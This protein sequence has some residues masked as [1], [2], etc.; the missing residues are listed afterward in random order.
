MLPFRLKPNSGDKGIRLIDWGS[1]EQKETEK[2]ASLPLTRVYIDAAYDSECLSCPDSRGKP[3]TT[4]KEF[5]IFNNAS[6]LPIEVSMSVAPANE[7]KLQFSVSYDYIGDSYFAS[8]PVSFEPA[9]L[10][11]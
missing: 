5:K 2:Y 1:L 3:S 10:T 7:L 9:E 6:Y 11:F 4:Y 8:D